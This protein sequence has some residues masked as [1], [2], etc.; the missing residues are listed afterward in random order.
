MNSSSNFQAQETEFSHQP[1]GR[2]L[3]PT[4]SPGLLLQ[5][6]ER[7]R[8]FQLVIHLTLEQ[9]SKVVQ[10]PQ[11]ISIYFFVSQ[12][13]IKESQEDELTRRGLYCTYLTE[14]ERNPLQRYKFS[15]VGGSCLE[16][17]ELILKAIFILGVA[18]PFVFCVLS[19][20]CCIFS[21]SKRGHLPKR[22]FIQQIC[23][24]KL[25]SKHDIAM[26]KT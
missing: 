23:T 14:C 5:L 7:N 15:N 6:A 1:E 12:L 8:H 17:M 4:T 11:A 26:C 18:A 3:H 9:T 13:I 19:S 10:T 2:S 22:G 16:T 21:A 24:Y 20:F 25:C